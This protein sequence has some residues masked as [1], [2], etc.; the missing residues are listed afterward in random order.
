V[1]A[2]IEIEA[3]VREMGIE[4][5][6]LVTAVGSSGTLSG[7]LAGFKLIDSKVRLLGIDVGNLWKRLPASIAAMAN[8]LCSR[9][10]SEQKFRPADIPLIEATYVGPTYGA[11]S[12]SGN[13]AI[14]RMARCEGIVLDPV[15][16]GKAFAGLVDRVGKKALGEAEP[17]IFLHTGGGPALFAFSED[18]VSKPKKT[19][20]C[21]D[22]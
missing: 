18:L 15:Y 4:N 13:E 1:R 5:A 2:A 11:A 9:L 20:G 8:G 17:I 19:A 10:G 7:L 16:T 22:A 3:Q 6:W 21:A 14:L 12:K